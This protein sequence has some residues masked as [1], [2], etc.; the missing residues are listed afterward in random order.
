[1]SF[2]FL[3]FSLTPSCSG[4]RKYIPPER[5]WL[6]AAAEREYSTTGDIWAFGLTCVELAL[7][8]VRAVW[9]GA[10]TG[11]CCDVMAGSQGGGGVPGI[12]FSVCFTAPPLFCCL[13][14]SIR[15]RWRRTTTWCGRVGSGRRGWTQ[16]PSMNTC[17]DLRPCRRWVPPPP[18][19]LFVQ[20]MV[21]FRGFRCLV[22]FLF[23][24]H[25][26]SLDMLPPLF[27]LPVVAALLIGLQRVCSQVPDKGSGRSGQRHF[28]AP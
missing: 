6:L 1:M 5:F 12:R 21:E 2:F 3:H 22:L 25:F 7:G 24:F 11:A 16:T 15:F 27:S 8:R 14:A 28:S 9:P 20:M 10:T 4:T 26:A 13:P 18:F 17:W 19:P 23:C